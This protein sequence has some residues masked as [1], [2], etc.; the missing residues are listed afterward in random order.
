MNRRVWR[1]GAS[2]RAIEVPTGTCLDGYGTRQ[3]GSSG[4]LRP[5][6][7]NCLYLEAGGKPALVVSLDLLA[8]DG[9]WVKTLKKRLQQR[10][11][12]PLE[13]IF[14]A[15]SHT[16]S[17]P[18]G[19]RR[20]EFGSLG[21]CTGGPDLQEA[22]ASTV[23][24][25]AS[26]AAHGAAEADLSVS[27]TRVS[28]VAANRRDPSGPA[29]K[30]LTAV[31]VRQASGQ[32]LA[33]LWHFA[34][35]PTVLDYRNVLVSPD[36]PGEVR[37][38]LRDRFGP[39]LPVLYLNGAAADVSTRFTRRGSGPEEL[40][41]LALPLANAVALDGISLEP[42][43]PIGRLAQS[44]LRVAPSPDLKDAEQRVARAEEALLA[45]RDSGA[46]KA[47]VRLREVEWMG[48]SKRLARC[49]MPRPDFLSAEVQVLRLGSLAL[50]GF[51]GE[52]YAQDGL[53]V[54]EA[55]GRAVILAVGYTGDYLGYLPPADDSEGYER[56][57]AW[58]DPGEVNQLL[59]L[60]R[61]LLEGRVRP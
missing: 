17:G 50:V 18:V 27:I 11:G 13:T 36:L 1:T 59:D 30:R 38:L 61:Q 37:Q 39:S 14:V 15:A 5:L 20:S 2:T 40:L 41:R 28:G 26:E 19:F 43:E 24:E 23:T 44:R 60:A 25:A 51:P 16:H 3:G 45:L 7:A 12:L 53:R 58:A 55:P 21:L 46:P 6:E 29:D 49:R 8:V 54:A 22:V 31:A 57:S 32:L 34:C 56:D 35:H 33:L 4:T 48:A 10:L 47:A 42:S 9:A 52:L